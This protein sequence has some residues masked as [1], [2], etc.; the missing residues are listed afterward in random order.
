MKEQFSLLLTNEGKAIFG[1]FD[2]LD[3]IGI[4]AHNS[5]V[6][7]IVEIGMLPSVPEIFEK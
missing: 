7:L 6:I 2:T 5:L 3:G 4:F 1:F